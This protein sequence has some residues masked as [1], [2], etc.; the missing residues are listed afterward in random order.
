[1]SSSKT[2]SRQPL[3]SRQRSILIAFYNQNPYPS[4]SERHLLVETT[5]RTI[6]QIQ[7]WFSNRRVCISLEFHLK[8]LSIYSEMILN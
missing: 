5:G 6:K 1:M 8:F 7:D 3:T 4:A 2:V